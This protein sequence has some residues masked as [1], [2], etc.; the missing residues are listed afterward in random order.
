L[1]ASEEMQVESRMADVSNK[2][3]LAFTDE[4]PGS[5]RLSLKLI[6]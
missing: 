2:R 6:S 5:S 1:S 3:V 4:S